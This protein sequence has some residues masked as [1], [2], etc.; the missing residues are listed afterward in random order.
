MLHRVSNRVI[1]RH[2]S[3]STV[4]RRMCESGLHGQIAAKDP[5]LKDN[6]N[7]KRLACAKKHEKW[8]LDRWKCEIFP[9][10]VSL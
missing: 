6:N 7:K 10:T 8:T 4:Q 1:N 2:I 5:L 3:T 9:N